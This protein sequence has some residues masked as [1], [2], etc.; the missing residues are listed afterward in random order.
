[1]SNSDIVNQ[2]LG[3]KTIAKLP[4][5]AAIIALCGLADAVYLTI[6]HYTAEPVPCGE[7]FDCGAV[8]SSQYA[9]M[10]GVPIAIFGA[11][12]YFT[13]FSLAVL[14]VFGNRLTWMLF[15]VQ[16]ILMSLFTTWLL[17]VQK[18]RIEAFCQFCLISAAITFTLLL[19]A[20]ISKFW[21]STR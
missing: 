9:V 12:A 16:V 19:I 15:G 13:A 1:M 2:E 10:F 4:I 3:G 20:L 7:A 17:Y 14:T 11:I 5:L 21:R 8:L 18:Y 6:H